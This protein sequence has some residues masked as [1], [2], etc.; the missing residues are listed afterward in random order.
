MA[1]PPPRRVANRRKTL[2]GVTI[3]RTVNYSIRRSSNRVRAKKKS[4]P[5]AVAAESFV[6]RGLGIIQN[7]EEVTELAMQELS[8]RFEGQVPDHVLAA[9]R[10]LFQVGFQEEEEIDAALLSHGGAAGLELGD[11]REDAVADV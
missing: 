1:S 9:M 3:A 7:G 11:E 2:A 6:C 8:R 10:E 4:V 5:V